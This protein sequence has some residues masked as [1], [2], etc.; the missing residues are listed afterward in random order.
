MISCKYMTNKDVEWAAM[1]KKARKLSISACFSLRNGFLSTIYPFCKKR[2]Q[3]QEIISNFLA[4]FLYS[5]NVSLY[6]HCH[7]LHKLQLRSYNSPK[8]QMCLFLFLFDIPSNL[9]Q[10]PGFQPAKHS[11]LKLP[12]KWRNNF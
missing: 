8:K 12:Q 1:D 7:K 3:L 6:T 10:T 5:Q 4:K 11:N 2:N 9:I